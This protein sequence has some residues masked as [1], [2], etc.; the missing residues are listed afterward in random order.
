VGLS[1]FATDA[2]AQR[3]S[4]VK[5]SFRWCTVAAVLSS[6]Q[7][8][9]TTTPHG[10]TGRLPAAAIAQPPTEPSGCA[11]HEVADPITNVCIA[12][13]GAQP[14]YGRPTIAPTCSDVELRDGRKWHD[15]LTLQLSSGATTRLDC[16]RMRFRGQDT[17]VCVVRDVDGQLR[18]ACCPPGHLDPT[19]PEC[20]AEGS[21]DWMFERQ[22]VWEW[23]SAT[24]PPADRCEPCVWVT[25]AQR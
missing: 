3:C 16:P 24:E 13:C 5:S 19:D 22:R 20:V 9:N 4:V 6:C 15:Q 12:D 11:E 25:G 23:C 21:V 7:V 14:P 18:G 17:P 10:G 8:T 1:F 2:H